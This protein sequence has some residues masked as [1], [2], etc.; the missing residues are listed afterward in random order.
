MPF[1]VSPLALS[2]ESTVRGG[3][4]LLGFG[5]WSVGV[6]SRVVLWSLFF[7]FFV[8]VEFAP[9]FFSLL[10]HLYLPHPI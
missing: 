1:G 9:F 2:L 6:V 4:A 8:G 5:G 10:P 3:L 7:V